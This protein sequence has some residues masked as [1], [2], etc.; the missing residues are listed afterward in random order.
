MPS[1]SQVCKDGDALE[2][3]QALVANQVDAIRARIPRGLGTAVCTQC[4]DPIPAERR[5]AI[6]GVTSCVPCQTEL[7]TEAKDGAVRDAAAREA[8][9][10]R[11]YLFFVERQLA[12]CRRTAR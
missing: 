6:P 10:E 8:L 12:R 2:N 7:E 3:Q 4:G 9:L 1:P 11:R 5:E